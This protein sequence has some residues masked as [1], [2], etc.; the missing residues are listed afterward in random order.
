MLVGW[1]GCSY[2]GWRKVDR[3][4]YTHHFSTSTTVAPDP[5]VQADALL[6]IQWPTCEVYQNLDDNDLTLA[7]NYGTSTRIFPDRLVE[8]NEIFALRAGPFE[9]SI[10]FAHPKKTPPPPFLIKRISCAA[11]RSEYGTKLLVL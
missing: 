2:L 5:K 8:K 11:A 4:L 1:N 10:M 6:R 3:T 7:V 9:V